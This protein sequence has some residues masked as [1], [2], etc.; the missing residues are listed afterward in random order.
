MQVIGSGFGRTGTLSTKH[1]LEILGFGP[2]HHMEEVLRHPAEGREWV[3]IARG[4]TPD[5]AQ[6]MARYGS[7]VD[8]PASI[9]WKQLL[10]AFPDAKVLHTVRDPERWYDST[11]STIFRS[12]D[13]IT[14]WVRA[15]TPAGYPVEIAR[16]M[17]WD[18]LFDGRFED[19]AHAI[20]VYER[21][22]TDVVASVPADRLLVFDVAQG[23]EP[24]CA[25]LDV[26]VPDRPFPRVNDRDA[27]MRRMRAARWAGRL[28]PAVALAALGYAARPAVR[29][30]Q[31]RVGTST[32]TADM[33]TP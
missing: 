24:L 6:L 11:R 26:P 20:A 2:C 12:G 25:F 3:R 22:T 1:A 18:G 31:R 14:G 5:W 15:A 16:R 29:M 17:V 8:F 23:W 13:F 4:G 33:T 9:V 21:W 7:C 10:E 27:L 32:D 28:L 19:R 30:A